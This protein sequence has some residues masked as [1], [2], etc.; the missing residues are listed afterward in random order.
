MACRPT[1]H[2]DYIDMRRAVCD[3]LPDPIL[4][5]P[6]KRQWIHGNTPFKQLIGIWEVPG[7]G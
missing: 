5:K 6:A 4:V 7:R 3:S 1:D 2:N